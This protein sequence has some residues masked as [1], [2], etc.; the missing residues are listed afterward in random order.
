MTALEITQDE[1]RSGTMTPEHL[2][3]GVEAIRREGFVVLDSVIDPEHVAVLRERMLADVDVIMARPKP[4]FNFIRGNIQ[5]DPP[6]A[7]PYLFRDVLVNE[8]IITITKA[9]LG[10]APRSSFYSGNTNLP[11]SDRQPVHVDASHLWANMATAH[12]AHTLV[13]NVP[14]VDMNPHNGSIELW[15]AS[16]LDTTMAYGRSDT[17]VPEEKLAERRAFAPPIQPDVRSGGVLIRDMRLW[18]AGAPNHSSAARPMIAMIHSCGW[19]PGRPI[20][21]LRG[22]EALLQHPDLRTNATFV[23]GPIDYVGRHERPQFKYDER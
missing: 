3:T 14:V 22:S 17:R 5:Q 2:A 21:F 12:P 19:W 6:P 23:D 7:P 20:E 8:M 13:I 15:P 16:H 18:H 1:I 4:P 11:G 10:P 9:I